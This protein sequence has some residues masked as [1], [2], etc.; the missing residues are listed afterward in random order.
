M[1]LLET[2]SKDTTPT[3]SAEHTQQA[4]MLEM[5]FR[6]Q[7]AGDQVEVAVRDAW[8]QLSSPFPE[9]CSFSA[10]K[11]INKFSGTSPK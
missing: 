9:I 3:D 11:N 8:K 2:Y 7:S 6:V 1:M 10:V 5:L 4:H